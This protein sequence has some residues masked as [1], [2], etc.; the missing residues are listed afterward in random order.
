MRKYIFTVLG[1]TWAVTA[2]LFTDNRFAMD[3]IALIMLVPF[4]VTVIFKIL[5]ERRT[6]KKTAILN[7]NFNMKAF[8]FGILYPIGFILICTA[9]DLL[10]WHP[11]IKTVKRPLVWIVMQLVTMLLGLFSSLAE[12]YGWRG[13]LLP[14]L[15][16]RYSRKKSVCIT[17]TVW[18]LFHMPAVYLLTRMT[19]LGN[20]VL[21]CLVQAG[22]VF[23]LNIAFCYCYFLSD[24]VIPVIFFHSVWNTINTS[25]LGDIYNG[26]QGILKGDI[27]LMNGEGIMGLIIGILCFFVIWMIMFPDTRKTGKKQS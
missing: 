15:C 16:S 23:T 19:G 25:V 7:H 22:V 18:V 12:E 26:K 3:Y 1:I 11:D 13:Y 21:V 4:A 27:F 17:G 5:E 10:L 6:G 8:L 24:N 14:H 9:A 2:L 20:P